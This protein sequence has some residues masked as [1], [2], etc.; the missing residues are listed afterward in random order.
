M[1]YKTHI[2]S[3]DSFSENSFSKTRSN[4][5]VILPLPDSSTEEFLQTS[6]KPFSSFLIRSRRN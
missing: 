4:I 5:F 6:V 1:A 2:P 3:V